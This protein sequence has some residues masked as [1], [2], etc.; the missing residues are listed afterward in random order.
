MI[1]N[2]ITSLI[3]TK[4]KMAIDKVLIPV[5]D[6]IN[7]DMKNDKVLSLVKL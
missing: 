2:P 1:E 4:S 7:V 5:S 3:L 6:V